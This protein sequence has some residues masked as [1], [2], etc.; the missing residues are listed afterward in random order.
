MVALLAL[1][2]GRGARSSH[3]INASVTTH[4]TVV[5]GITTDLRAIPKTVT[6]NPSSPY[7]LAGKA[8]MGKQV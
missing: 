5:G 8:L 1:L 3:D 4:T 6:V 7:Y 2:S